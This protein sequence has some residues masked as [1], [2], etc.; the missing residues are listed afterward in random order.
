MNITVSLDPEV[1]KSLLARAHQRGLTLDA[2]IKDLV[3]KEASLATT[4]RSG[5]EK[6]QAFVAWAKSH[7]TTKPLSDEAISRATL[8]P[9]RP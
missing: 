1:E 9:D 4:Q 7:R 2:Y 5:K 6:A 8:Y 3:K